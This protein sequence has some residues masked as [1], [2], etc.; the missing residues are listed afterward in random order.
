MTTTT[1]RLSTRLAAGALVAGIALLGAPAYAESMSA[2][3]PADATASLY[4]IRK[5]SANHQDTKLVVEVKVTDL[6][7]ESDGGP[8]SMSLFIDTDRSQ[9]GPELRLGTGLQTGTDYQLVRMK[10]WRAVGE[11]L[12]CGHKVKLVADKDTVRFRVNAGCLGSPDELR[13]GVKMVDLW[14]GSHPVRD[15]FKGVRHWTRWLDRG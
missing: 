12:T 1:N 11:P 7:L 13:V 2:G 6:L 5:V 9:A 14:D 15:W 4:D 10:N 8:A 3:D